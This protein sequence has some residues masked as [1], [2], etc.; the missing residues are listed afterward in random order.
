M[1]NYQHYH[2]QS[3]W[4]N[5]HA[6]PEQARMGNHNDTNPGRNAYPETSQNVYGP[7][8]HANQW[9]GASSSSGRETSETWNSPHWQYRDWHHR[10]NIPFSAHYPSHP[11]GSSTQK[12]TSSNSFDPNIPQTPHEN[13][14]QRTLQYVEQC[15]SNWN[16]G[17][18]KNS[19]TQ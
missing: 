4:G 14:Y 19:V 5:H 1:N 2:P 3:N 9:H 8:M 11:Q 15:Q 7:S 17:I 16:S 12:L 6:F 18:D 13:N 10:E